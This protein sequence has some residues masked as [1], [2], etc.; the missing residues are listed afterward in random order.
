MRLG[1]IESLCELYRE[2][3]P[4]WQIGQCIVMSEMDDLFVS[5]QQLRPRQTYR[6]TC[7]SRTMASPRN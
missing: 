4:I 2:E 6:V 3:R 1:T 5:L 7:S